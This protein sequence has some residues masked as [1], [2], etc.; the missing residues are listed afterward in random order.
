MIAG[1]SRSRGRSRSG[2]PFPPV[3]AARVPGPTAVNGSWV[4]CATGGPASVLKFFS[5]WRYVGRAVRRG[6]DRTR[7]GTH[8]THSAAVANVEIVARA[9]IQTCHREWI[10]AG[11][12]HRTRTGRKSY[13]TVF[14][15]PK[16]RSN[17]VR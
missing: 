1:G 11:R 17:T 10:A 9:R 8:I 15:L 12:D 4:E 14:D 16:G 2:I 3:I 7:P 13:R 5:E 6:S